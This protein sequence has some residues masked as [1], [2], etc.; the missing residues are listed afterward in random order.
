MDTHELYVNST[1][2]WLR[3]NAPRCIPIP[4]IN[5]KPFFAD[6][7]SEGKRPMWAFNIKGHTDEELWSKWDAYGAYKCRK[8]LCLTLRAGLLVLDVDSKEV[9]RAMEAAIPELC[10]TSI[11][12][13]RKGRHYFFRTTPACL[14]AGLYD[15]SRGLI[16]RTPL[17][18]S[19]YALSPE[20]RALPIDIKTSAKTGTG[21][22]IIIAPS[23]N[24]TWLQGKR[25]YECPPTPIPEML[26]RFLIDNRAKSHESTNES[27][28]HEND[29]THESDTHENETEDLPSVSRAPS[30]ACSA[31]P[32][33]SQIMS[34]HEEVRLLVLT[35]LSSERATVYGPW[36]EVGMVLKNSGKPDEFYSL[37]LEFSKRCTD[38]RKQASPDECMKKW[39]TFTRSQEGLS[40]GS[41][42]YWASQDNPEAYRTLMSQS[43]GHMLDACNVS[44]HS[45][46][47]ALLFRLYGTRFKCINIRGRVWYHYNGQRWCP[48]Q[49]GHTLRK[50]MSREVS[51]MFLQR[52]QRVSRSAEQVTQQC[53][54]DNESQIMTESRKKGFVN[55]SKRLSDMAVRLDNKVYKEQVFQEC[56]DLFH[57]AG[58][59]SRLDSQPNLLGFEDGV[60]DLDAS[61]FR[62]G[63]PEDY[64]SFNTGYSFP[65]EDDESVQRQLADFVSSTQASQEHH[66][67]VMETLAYFLHGRKYMELLYFFTGAHGRNGKSLLFNTLMASVLGDYHYAP[68]ASILMNSKASGGGPSPEVV[69]LAGKRMVVASEPDNAGDACF[70]VS[71]L[72]AWRGNDFISARGLYQDV[73]RIKPQFSVC[74]LM[75]NKPPL[76]KLDRAFASTLRIVEFPWEFVQKPALPHQKQGDARLKGLYGERS[77]YAAQFMRMLLRT[78]K[79]LH[80]EFFGSCRQIETP[81]GVLTA[82]EQYVDDQDQLGDWLRRTFDF[83]E[84]SESETEESSHTA[85]SLR[86]MYNRSLRHERPM[87]RSAFKDAMAYHGLISVKATRGSTRGAMTY[88]GLKPKEDTSVLQHAW[89]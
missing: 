31:S 38:L 41:L 23:P 71:R 82:T 73:T 80:H 2:S 84:R 62:S 29:G 50:L 43:L 12:E 27:D 24:K 40:V 69:K 32:F 83:V 86:D 19:L 33:A 18:K 66:K 58:F 11:Q 53:E 49:D 78:Y 87:S 28:T 74:V 44:T 10:E 81:P 20:G 36:I 61:L 48:D 57:D 6:N 60:Y 45:P 89:E 37:W 75:N 52:S 5:N 1:V 59:L 65:Q 54:A 72:K 7:P 77:E 15:S 39:C 85:D 70:R 68:D 35:V 22:I 30:V 88:F 42:R 64:V 9:T 34:E 8:G 21:G 67:Y 3:A 14:D 16:P 26:L 25:L 79:A 47:A 51:A 63:R 17:A 55:H 46:M 56:A 76:D 13:T 4:T